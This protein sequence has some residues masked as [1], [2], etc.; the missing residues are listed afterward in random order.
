ML[1][2]ADKK[3]APSRE[4]IKNALLELM[5]DR[6]LCNITVSEL[7]TR[8]GVSRG[9][10]YTHFNGIASVRDELIEDMFAILDS[11]M[12]DIFPNDLIKNSYASLR[13]LADMLY[14]G[15]LPSEK[16]SV[17]LSVS[18]LCE[19]LSLW[20]TKYLLDDKSFV[21]GFD[22]EMHAEI[23]ARYISGGIVHT[24]IMWIDQDM[25][26]TP[27]RLAAD[28]GRLITSGYAIACGRK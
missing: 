25:P 16:L 22:D 10:F 4:L 15:K 27:E 28:L 24:F 11:L 5:K 1:M 7:L 23:F 20:L 2:A 17:M 8:A 19:Q 21:A 12:A 14:N 9:T 6:E 18:E 3:I 26:C 13:K